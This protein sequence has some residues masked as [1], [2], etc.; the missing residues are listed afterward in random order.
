MKQSCYQNEK[1][2]WNN[3]RQKYVYFTCCPLQRK[4]ELMINFNK[5]TR[6]VVRG[7]LRHGQRYLPVKLRIPPPNSLFSLHAH[8]SRP[9]YTNPPR[10]LYILTPIHPHLYYVLTPIHLSRSTG[11]RTSWWANKRSWRASP[12]SW[13]RPLPR[14]PATN[15]ALFLGILQYFL[16][17]CHMKVDYKN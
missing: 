13:S 14:C 12:R 2:K 15:K 4:S 9:P 3:W 10:Y 17:T 7:I 8:H 6:C 5:V 11:W 1:M 16:T